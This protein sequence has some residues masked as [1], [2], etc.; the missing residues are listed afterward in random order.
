MLQNILCFNYKACVHIGS[1]FEIK[2]L[3]I[4]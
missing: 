3:K 4:L 1:P 2:D